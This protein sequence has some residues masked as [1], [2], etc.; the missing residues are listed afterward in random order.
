MTEFSNPT[1]SLVSSRASFHI[2]DPNDPDL[3]HLVQRLPSVPA[4][5]RLRPI[6]EAVP[7]AQD[8]RDEGREAAYGWLVAVPSESW[9]RARF[10]PLNVKRIYGRRSETDLRSS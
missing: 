3:W 5:K 7:R 1:R 2:G 10:D 8:V 4:R 9:A 6:T